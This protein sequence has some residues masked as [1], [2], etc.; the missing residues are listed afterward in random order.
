MENGNVF[1][2][3]MF[4]DCTY[5]G[6][7]MARAG[8]EY[9]VGREANARFGE[10]L[11][12]VRAETPK[13]QFKVPVDPYLTPGDPQSGLVPFIQPGDGGTPGEGDRAVQAY[14]FRLCLTK[15]PKNRRPIEPPPGYEPARYE[16]LGRYLQA[17]IASGHQP[18]LAEFLKLDMVTEDK[19][20]V[21]N[22]GGFSTD[23]IGANYEYPEA[24]YDKRAQI[25]QEHEH[26]IRGFL[27]F[28]ATDARVPEPMRQEMQEWG[29]CKDEFEDTGGWP[30][31]M[32][33]REA[34]RMLGG[35]VMT[36]KNCRGA[37]VAQDAVGLGAYN[38]DSHNCQRIVKNGRVE[39]EG[40]VQVPVKPYPISYRSIVPPAE[41]CENLFVPVA[42]SATHIAYG[43]IRMEPVFMILGQSAATAASLAI[44]GGTAVQAVDY[45]KLRTQLL[46][47]RQV[48]EWSAPTAEAAA[49]AAPPTKL[50]GIVQ[51]DSEAEKT[52]EWQQGQLAGTQ[53]VGA[54]Y[55]HD[56][57]AHKGAISIR[58]RRTLEAGDYE[59]LLHFPANANRA[60]NVPVLVE[61]RTVNG[62]GA[63]LK[64]SVNQ[65]SSAEGVESLGR[66]SVPAGTT[67]QIT[68]SNEGTDG[69]VIA[70]GVQLLK[71]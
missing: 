40:D 8:V 19:T 65:R 17:L 50:E 38:M 13:H 57:D 30:H 48:L 66:V 15:N 18:K 29:L 23:Y 54:G 63:A 60:T 31:A 64:M 69:H 52:G 5:E 11:N 68:I 70:D 67:L 44:D 1:R 28:L 36:E 34:R 41:K 56:G 62:G 7:L 37:E 59:I 71:R 10:T 49:G 45:A 22:Q 43:S 26:Y 58:W 32:Y 4:I 46:A 25:W 24:S 14:N 3:K 35:Y 42:L 51:D 6:D 20:D 53:H 12:G 16:L 61:Q 39:N 21:N 47:D 55:L 2:G 33:V 9:M 27:T